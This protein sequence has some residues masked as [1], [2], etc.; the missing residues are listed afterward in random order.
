[1][2]TINVLFI[3]PNFPGQF[4]ALLTDLIAVPN[5]RV[6]FI[7][8]HP[9]AAMSGV[10]IEKYELPDV[11]NQ[12]VHKY[13][14][15][16]NSCLY[17]A[18]EV[19]KAAIKLHHDNKF[20]PTVIIGHIGWAGTVFMKDVFPN[21]RLIGYCEWF[22]RPETS[23][24]S[25]TGQK[26]SSDLKAKTR[27]LNAPSLLSLDS[28][29]SGVSPM[30]WQSSTYPEHFRRKIEVIH[31]GI[32]TDICSPKS[33][34]QLLVPGANLGADTK[35][36]TYISRALEPA[37]GFFT[38][39]E[40]AEKILKR[41]K[42]IHFVVVGRE[43][44]AYSPDTGNGPSYKQQAMQRYDCD[45]DRVHFT[46]KLSYEHYLSV[47]RNSMVHIYLS[48]P[49][50][51][52]WSLLEAMS[53]S[54]TIVASN[55]APVTEVIEHDVNGRLVS[56]F[57]ADALANEVIDLVNDKESSKRLSH[58]ARELVIQRY[59]RGKCVKQWKE[60]I[61]RTIREIE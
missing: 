43:R 57:D 21:S 9:D 56:F 38:F 40:A 48:S 58:A 4:K 12:H 13:L 28:I 59:D 17:E 29:D 14:K 42:D 16:T 37:R 36:V 30:H 20:N 41:E 19:T 22:Y 25:F 49:L 3:H 52:S 15:G 33:R 11:N 10:L 35:I 55:N 44:S 5:V 27:L 1:M 51:L 23:W 32:D 47:L 50:F 45:W 24:E 18:Q 6:G 39:M 7:T 26:I 46:G 2:K 53:A 54:C 31:E 8:R 34:N 61:L 60:L